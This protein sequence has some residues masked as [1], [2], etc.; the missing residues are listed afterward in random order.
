MHV[1][2]RFSNAFLPLFFFVSLFLFRVRQFL[3]TVTISRKAA[4]AGPRPDYIISFL[5]S[6]VLIPRESRA[7]NY[8]KGTVKKL[9]DKNTTISLAHFPVKLQ[10]HARFSLCC[11]KHGSERSCQAF[12]SQPR[13]IAEVPLFLYLR[14][15]KSDTFQNRNCQ[16]YRAVMISC[17]CTLLMLKT[18]V[19]GFSAYQFLSVFQGFSHSH[20]RRMAGSGAPSHPTLLPIILCLAFLFLNFKALASS[21]TIAHHYTHR[22]APYR[23]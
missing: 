2:K 8:E 21:S 18:H 7:R 10:S 5:L 22:S 19:F 4:C 16:V 3:S 1:K 23:L 11:L 13:V 9:Q 12:F 14:A 6:S 17:L 20:F 15:G